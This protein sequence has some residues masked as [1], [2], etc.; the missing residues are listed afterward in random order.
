LLPTGIDP[1]QPFCPANLTTAEHLKRAILQNVL[2]GFAVDSLGKPPIT[3][4]QT[5]T[6]LRL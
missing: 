2:A 6:E 3:Y 4:A 5:G 1:I